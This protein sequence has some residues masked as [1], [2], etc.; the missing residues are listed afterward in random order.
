MAL[1]L[2]MSDHRSHARLLPGL[3]TSDLEIEAV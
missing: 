3:M 1:P 2:N